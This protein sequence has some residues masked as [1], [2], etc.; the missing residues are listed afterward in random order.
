[1]LWGMRLFYI[2][3][4]LYSSSDIPARS[5]VCLLGLII[6]DRSSPPGCVHPNQ[7]LLSQTAATH[8]P[9]NALC[10]KEEPLKRYTIGISAKQEPSP[11]KD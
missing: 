9:A 8:T 5:L 2:H 4:K 11:Q 6:L 1:M 7:L 3:I 10:A